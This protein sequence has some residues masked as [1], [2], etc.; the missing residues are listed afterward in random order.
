[1]KPKTQYILQYYKFKTM[2]I[3]KFLIL[4]FSPLILFNCTGGTKN[5]PPQPNDNKIN[6]ISNN[7]NISILLDL[8]DRI[9]PVKYPN[10]SMEYYQRDAQ[11]IN[12]I[13][14]SFIKHLKSKK[15]IL[16]ND[17]IGL[18]F[19]PEPNDSAINDI[20]KH[21][22]ISFS[23]N[24]PKEQLQE[25]EEKYQ[26]LPLKIYE[27]AI[28]DGDYVGSD[29]W[30]FFKDKVN[31]YCI[32]DEHRNIL[33]I[34]T[35]GYMYH[36]DSEMKEGNKTSYLT[37]QLIRQFNLNRSDWEEKILEN[38]NGFIPAKKNLNNLEVLVLGINPDKKNPFEGDVI[39]N[40]WSV[41][42]TEMG[43]SKFKILKTDLPSNL[44]KPVSEF[45]N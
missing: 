36:A 3:I 23:K 39:E 42:L 43:I 26:T 25:T 18:Y 4:L 34:L 29:I 32:E 24:S 16:L 17:Q 35:D 31:D 22:K 5:A 38:S 11:Y 44:E 1:M 45:L 30:R 20:S 19:N 33:V 9:D 6:S 40:Y 13:A 7:L 14:Q 28:K 15:V 21:L 27:A 10:P 2:K 37:P 41:W 8:S 12:M